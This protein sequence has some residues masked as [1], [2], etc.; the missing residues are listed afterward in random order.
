MDLDESSFNCMV[1]MKTRSSELRRA[2]ET[3]LW[4]I[5]Y[6][7]LFPGVWLKRK[8]AGC[9]LEDHVVLIKVFLFIS[10]QIVVTVIFKMG[11]VEKN[12]PVGKMRFKTLKSRLVLM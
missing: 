1:R 10:F 12:D 2:L 9:W 8:N 11:K 5:K 4:G 6:G 7:L 3:R